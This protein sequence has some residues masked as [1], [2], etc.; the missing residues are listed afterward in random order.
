MSISYVETGRKRQK[1]RTREAI[2]AATRELLTQS[3]N[4]TVEQ[5]ADAAGVSRATAYR[6]FPNQRDLLV[7]TH[8]EIDVQSLLGD[9]APE[10]VTERLDLV[11]DAMAKMLIDNE[12]ELRTAL[13]LSL[14]ADAARRE[15]LVLRQGRAIGWLE[16]ALGPLKGQIPK[17]ERRRLVLAIRSAAGIEAFVWLCDV[18]GLSRKDAI[19]VMRWTARTLLA[20]VLHER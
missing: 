8:P 16:D 12:P 14:E 13:R 11:V 1:L 15:Q 2:I 19:E 10:D 5:A 4:P 9:D 17:R 7:A 18:A 20:S 3:A 6:Y